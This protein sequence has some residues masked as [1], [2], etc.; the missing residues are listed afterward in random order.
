MR[1]CVFDDAYNFCHMNEITMVIFVK[2]SSQYWTRK[3]KFEP[4]FWT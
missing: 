1:I 2:N 4:I 3:T